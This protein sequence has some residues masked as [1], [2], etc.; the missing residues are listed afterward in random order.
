MLCFIQFLDDI[1]HD[2][3]TTAKK[4][5]RMIEMLKNGQLI[6]LILVQ[7][8]RIKTAVPRNKDM[9]LYYIYCLYWNMYKIS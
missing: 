7:Y 6:F 5:K 3:D 8:K 4:S 9:T 2:S 1:K